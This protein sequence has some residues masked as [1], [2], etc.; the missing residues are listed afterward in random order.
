MSRIS[1]FL[2]AMDTECTFD[3][4]HGF[5]K[6]NLEIVG[7]VHS[8]LKIMFAD[9]IFKSNTRDAHADMEYSALTFTVCLYMLLYVCICVHDVYR[10]LIER[11]K[12][13][14]HFLINFDLE[15]VNNLLF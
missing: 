5:S 2:V 12:I 4:Y 3:C 15:L 9:V 10:P 14:H 7:V 1:L 11:A 13:Q 6:T 8:A